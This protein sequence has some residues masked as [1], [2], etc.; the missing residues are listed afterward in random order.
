MKN[1]IRN[2]PTWQTLPTWQKAAL[3]G[4]GVAEVAAFVAAW[5]DLSRRQPGQINGSKAIWRAALFV[6]GIGPA[7]Y[8]LKGRNTATWSEADIPDLSGKVA[9]V[10]GANSGLGYET[11]RA[12][13][14][15]GATVIMACR[16][17][18]KAEQAAASILATNPAGKVVIMELDLGDLNSV[19]GFADAFK[20][21]YDHLDL[22]I[23]NAGI[24]VPPQGQTEQGFETQFGV[25]HL[26]H[27]ALTA[28]LI[29]RLDATPGARIVTVSS[30]AH[31]FGQI[32][33]DDLNWQRRNYQRMPA[34]GQS[35]LANLLFTYELQR[36][37]S[38]SG[39]HT[40]A[41]AAHPGWATTS[42]QGEGA[43]M[44]VANRVFA[45]SAQMGAWPTLYA[46]TAP[47]VTGGEYIGPSGLAELGGV[48]QEVASNE[49]S[50]QLDTAQQLWSV[51]EELT[52]VPFPV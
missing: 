3:I 45:Q 41:L 51:S 17:R 5:A 16:N 29:D 38:A 18:G 21:K 44:Q 32:K 20:A 39:Q 23:N 12:L 33:F 49:A 50:H 31:H 8:F 47:S 43:A 1:N 36:R 13:A 27:F 15:H 28:Q 35:K 19:R 7:A 2:K 4:V 22:L 11:A 40:L 37:L 10:T 42:L 30:I 46:A 52:G 25:N 14:Q 9:V 34:Y 6:S 48:P 24:M 26:G